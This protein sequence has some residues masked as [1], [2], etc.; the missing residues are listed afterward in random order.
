MRNILVLCAEQIPQLLREAAGDSFTISTAPKDPSARNAALRE[1][2]III[3]EPTFEELQIAKKL[4]WVQAT[5][6]GVER[7]TQGEFPRGVQLTSAAGAF[8]QTI[9]EHALAMLLS[10]CRRLPTYCR[11]S[12]WRD[13]GCE[14]PLFGAKA[15][16]FGAG[17]IGT[18][19]ARLL[20]A[21]GVKTIGVCRNTA[22]SL[23]NF[24]SLCTLFDADK[25]LPTAD[26]LLCALPHT[27][28][29][30]G[31]FSAERLGRVKSGA[32]L[33]NVGRGSLIDTDALVKSLENGRLAG[34][35]LDVVN[36]EPLPARH[37]LWQMPNVIITPHVAGIGFGHLPRTEER[38]WQ[39]CSENIT[40][41]K[42]GEQ[43]RNA[44]YTQ[45]E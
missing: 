20:K 1:A 26:F 23:P 12:D 7:Y 44:V 43:L 29:T 21:F 30:L 16:V 28:E 18:Y 5:W 22:R 6:A 10:L 45:G 13:A 31:Y 34:A 4:R 11:K 2:E 25:F 14:I 27:K 42:N 40:R 9:A 15:L 41:Y 32:L 3:G 35:G 33:V 24:D 39:I 19:I 37:P 36:P 17:D 8:G 38:I